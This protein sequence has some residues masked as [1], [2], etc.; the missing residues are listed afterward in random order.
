MVSFEAQQFSLWWGCAST[1]CWND[2]T[3]PWIFLA[4]LLFGHKSGCSSGLS[5][6]LTAY[7]SSYWYH[8]YSSCVVSLELTSAV[9]VFC[10]SRFFFSYSGSR[11]FSH[12]IRISLLT[13]GR[14]KKKVG[15]DFNRDCLEFLYWGVIAIL[16]VLSLLLHEYN[17]FLFKCLISFNN[18]LDSSVYMFCTSF[19]ILPKHL[20]LFDTNESKVL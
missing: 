17:L 15:W 10:S 6:S 12:R 18:I 7:L 1:V 3:P 16:R 14:K 19:K 11:A 4:L 13:F 2:C 20:N 8:D 9:F 5:V